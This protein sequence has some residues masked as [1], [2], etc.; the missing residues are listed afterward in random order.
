LFPGRAKILF[1]PTDTN[2]F[3]HRGPVREAAYFF[4]RAREIEFAT[5]LLRQGQSLAVSGPRRIGKTSLLFHLAQ[6]EVAAAHGLGPETARWIYLDGGMLDGLDEEWL[7]GA[8]DRELGGEADAVPYGHFVERLR[9]LAAS[10]L[11]GSSPAAPRLIL[12]LD[13]FELIAANPRLG[14]ALFNRLRGLTTQYPLQFIT[15]SRDPLWQ[16]AFAHRETLSSPFFNIFAPLPLGLFSDEEAGA[17]LAALSTRGRKAGF[18]A[19][20]VAHILDL[21]GPHPLFLQ[22]AAYRTFAALG[23][24]PGK[25]LNDELMTSV[26]LQVLADL[27]PHLN[28]YWSNL[29]AEAQYTLAALPLLE[30]DVRTDAMGHLETAGLVR[31]GGYLGRALEE[32]VRRQKVA[33]LQQAG[34]FLIDT[35]RGLAA[36]SGRQVHLTPTEYTALR[37]FIEHP[38]QVLTP[39]EIEAA[40]WPG[41]FSPDPERARGIVKKLRAALGPA[42]EA[43]VNRRGQGY[44]LSLQ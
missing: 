14:P 34:P 19:E 9:A 37:L 6:P 23:G 1:V 41:E 38:G 40:L 17:L 35:R 21:A 25:K 10:R 2:P 27:E 15:A 36:V 28:Y 29:G 20:T 22:V 44:L 39:E 32:F 31:A 13:E 7:Y 30:R 12:A 42:G 4:G 11:A 24:H 18:A 43:I 3:F 33:G 5:D 26:R 8:V 16:L